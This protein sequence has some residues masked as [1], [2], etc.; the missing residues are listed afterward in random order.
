MTMSERTA[1]RPASDDN[2]NPSQH[3]LTDIQIDILEK[4]FQRNK[5]PTYSDILLSAALI[6]VSVDTAKVTRLENEHRKSEGDE[7]RKLV[8]VR[9]VMK[10]H[11][12]CYS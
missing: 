8:D 10:I 5:N 11:V 4:D 9:D 6:G 3:K 2:G 1:C 7:S 12:V